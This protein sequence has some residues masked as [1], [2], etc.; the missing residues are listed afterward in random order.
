MAT[1][2]LQVKDSILEKLLSL[3]N[4]FDRSEV[5]IMD[6]ETAVLAQK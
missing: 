5:E 4:Q 2:T 3:L 6:E 1:L